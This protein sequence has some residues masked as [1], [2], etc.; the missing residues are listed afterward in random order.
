VCVCVCVCVKY[1]KTT[2]SRWIIHVHSKFWRIQSPLS[3]K[4]GRLFRSLKKWVGK[5]V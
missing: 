3:K 5:C 1:K 2:K 4:M